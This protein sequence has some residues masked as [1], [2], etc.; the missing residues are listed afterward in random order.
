MNSTSHNEDSKAEQFVSPVDLINAA[1]KTN[2]FGGY[3]KTQVDELLERAADTL[4]HLLRE[5]KMLKEIRSELEQTLEKYKDIES[6]LRSALVSSQKMGENMITAAKLQAEALLQEARTAKARA[7]F[8]M[9]KLPDALRSEIQRLMDARERLRDELAAIVRSHESLITS[10]P[11]AE[12]LEELLQR[13]ERVYSVSQDDD[14]LNNH[15]NVSSGAEQ[16]ADT[17]SSQSHVSNQAEDHGYVN[18]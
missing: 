5:N 3:S 17:S 14:E 8:K 16:P 9:E 4:D 18:L 6:S 13:Q 10:I 15:W 12:I 2:L 7:I 11:R 1:L